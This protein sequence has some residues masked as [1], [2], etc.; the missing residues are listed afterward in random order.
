[1]RE[2]A[3]ITGASSGIGEQFARQ[4]AARGHDVVLVAR[5]AERLEQLAAELPTDAHAVPC[6]LST[7]AASLRERVAGLGVEIDLLVNNAGFRTSGPFLEHDP[8]RDAEQVRLNCE[9]VV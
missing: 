5:S 4:L 2:T 1:M 6:D 9:A 3:L 8:A 7:D